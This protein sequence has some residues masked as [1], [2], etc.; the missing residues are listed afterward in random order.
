[1]A[2]NVTSLKTH[3][4]YTREAHGDALRDAQREKPIPKYRLPY[5]FACIAL[6][7]VNLWKAIRRPW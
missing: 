3:P 1:M 2:N 6:A 5:P 7:W 4:R